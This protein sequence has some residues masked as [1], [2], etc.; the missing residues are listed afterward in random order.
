MSSRFHPPSSISRQLTFGSGL[1][2]ANVLINNSGGVWLADY[3]LHPFLQI[4]NHL[5]LISNFDAPEVMPTGV[6]LK[7]GDIFAFAML[8][9]EVFTGQKPFGCSRY[10]VDT[11]MQ[12]VEGKR[13]EKPMNVL[14]LG[15][16]DGIW[17]LVQRCW[18]QDYDE[19]PIIDD[20]VWMW[21]KLMNDSRGVQEH[22]EVTLKA[23]TGEDDLEGPSLQ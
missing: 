5:D 17:D 11:W 3:G 10:D 2:Q 1:I 16:S 12:M 19:R 9:V 22:P 14:G 15:F 7:P 13:P 4:H 18:A 23:L 8:V 21:E 6:I 20:V